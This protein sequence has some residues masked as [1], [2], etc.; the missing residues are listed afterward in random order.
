MMGAKSSLLAALTA[1]SAVSL[2]G[3][4]G[5]GT[6]QGEVKD[7][8][9]A[10]VPKAHVAIL[11]VETGRRYETATNSSGIYLFPAIEPGGYRMTVDVRGMQTWEG[12]LRLATGQEFS[13]DVVL[14]VSTASSSITVAGE[15][16]SPIDTVSGT[17]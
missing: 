16:G 11:R 6:L 5:A 17:L 7:S 9:G 4:T 3:Q 14:Q 10:L 8:T 2:W 12:S 1:V 15:V 13:V